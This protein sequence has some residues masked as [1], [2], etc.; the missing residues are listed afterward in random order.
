MDDMDKFYSDM[1]IPDMTGD[2]RTN[3]VDAILYEDMIRD[4]EYERT[5]KPMSPGDPLYDPYY[6]PPYA[7]NSP[8]Y[9]TFGMYE[10]KRESDEYPS[11]AG[12]DPDSM[13]FEFYFPL[14]PHDSY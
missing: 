3:V 12:S 6:R 2:G 14:D 8:E 5:G 4:M 7:G 13:D 9:D 1:G 10:D 11:G